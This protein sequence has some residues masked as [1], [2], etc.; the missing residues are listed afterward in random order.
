MAKGLPGGIPREDSVATDGVR[1]TRRDAQN[2]KNITVKS[3]NSFK[4]LEEPKSVVAMGKRQRVLRTNSEDK[5]SHAHYLIQHSAS[6]C[7]SDD[8]LIQ[9]SVRTLRS[10][11]YSHGDVQASPAEAL[12]GPTSRGVDCSLWKSPYRIIYSKFA[13][14]MASSSRSSE[15]GLNSI[16][17]AGTDSLSSWQRRCRK[18]RRAKNTKYVPASRLFKVD[19]CGGAITWTCSW[20][21]IVQSASPPLRVFQGRRLPRRLLLVSVAVDGKQDVVR[22]RGRQ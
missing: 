6:R 13:C 14:A 8:K 2:S 5:I 7:L 22:G 15:S 11:V 4:K 20:K 16:R 18:D 1:Q 3:N 19:Q 21:R 12:A 9:A 17:I 10:R